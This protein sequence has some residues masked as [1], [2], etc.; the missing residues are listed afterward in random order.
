M[1][2]KKHDRRGNPYAIL[3]ALAAAVTLFPLSCNYI[4]DGGIAAEWT[5][6]VAE[7]AQGFQNGKFYLF[8]SLEVRISADI[9]ENAMNSNLWFI[10]PGLMY[11]L[12]GKMVLAYRV[13][14]LL[15]Q[16]GTFLGASV[17]FRRIFAQER[18]GLAAC[19]GV[20]LYMTSPYRIYVCYDAANLSRAAAWMLLPFYVW[21]IYGLFVS[22]GGFR[23]LA[24]AAL[25]LAGTGFAD[26][27][28]LLAAAGITAL[29]SVM[30]R[31]VVP[32]LA[33]SA[34]CL[35]CFPGLLRLGRYL[36]TESYAQWEMPLQM[37]ME[38]GYHVGQFFGSYAFRNGKPGMGLGMLIC[39]LT[40]LWLRFVQ[41]ERGT[42]RGIRGF[43]AIA[44]FLTALSLACFPWDILQRLGAWSVKLI[45]LIGTPAV[46]WGMATAAYCIPAADSMER[47]SRRENEPM[48]QAVPVIVVLF[49]VGICV[50]Q[51]NMLTYSRLPLTIGF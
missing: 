7:M 30:A 45:S 35:L 46:F 39:M 32:C 14:L 17:C 27:V 26:V 49:A 51:C 34:G 43:S 29:A 20:A 1:C 21:A 47:I 28:I 3:S 11:L 25:A 9:A 8:P 38:K 42:D 48:V 10:L 13:Y 50:Y 36:F 2:T 16:I 33:V 12:T 19:V 24:W 18:M 31:R 23:E 22:G 40:A 5:A 4:M 15:V 41:G 6:R 44:L 37:I